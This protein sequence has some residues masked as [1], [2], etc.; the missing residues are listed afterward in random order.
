MLSE[1]GLELSRFGA[2]YGRSFF[3]MIVIPRSLAPRSLRKVEGSMHDSGGRTPLFVILPE[4]S[5][6]AIM[7][8]GIPVPTAPPPM[9]QRLFG[10]L[11]ASTVI[12]L[13]LPS[14]T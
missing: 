14:F 9:F 6:C 4:A 11:I 5:H 8:G 1:S 12:T 13:L 10:K 7:E 3:S 2:F